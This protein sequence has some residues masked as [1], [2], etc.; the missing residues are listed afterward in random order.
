MSD[1][2]FRFLVVAGL[3]GLAACQYYSHRKAKIA[4]DEIRA[5]IA[6]AEAKADAEK[7]QVAGKI[8]ALVAEVEALKEQVNNGLS[9]AEIIAGIEGLG[10]KI[11][12]IL[13][14]EPAP[15]A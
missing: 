7:E 5:A 14:T 11:D 2:L 13:T 3:V 9:K 4:M 1:S 12:N 15:D 8:S 10:V 6:A